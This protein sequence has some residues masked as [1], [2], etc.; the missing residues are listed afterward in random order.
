MKENDITG[1]R[2]IVLMNKYAP[3]STINLLDQKYPRDYKTSTSI[4]YTSNSSFDNM[5]K[6]QNTTLT[7]KGNDSL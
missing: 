4:L 7:T 5:N 2:S 1:K 6:Y 3:K